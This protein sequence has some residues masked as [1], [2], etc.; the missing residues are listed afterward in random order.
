MRSKRSG[1]LIFGSKPEDLGMWRGILNRANREEDLRVFSPRSDLRFNFLDYEL[2]HG[3]DTRSITKVITTIGETLRSNDTN[4]TE[5]ADFFEKQQDRQVYNGVHVM[6]LARK[7]IDAWELQKFIAGAAKTP[8][9][10]A[11]PEWQSGFHNQCLAE[12]H[13]A[14]MSAIDRHDLELAMQYWVG[15]YPFMADRTRSSIETGVMGILHVFNTG[16][17]RELVSTTTNVSLFAPCL[18]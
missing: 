12:A 5:N 11:R 7:K 8:A 15:E 2:E 17:V 13:A 16:Q 18:T 10:I 1:G 3:G 14:S 4:G 6:K 9:E